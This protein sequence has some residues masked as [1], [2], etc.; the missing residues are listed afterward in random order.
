MVSTLPAFY[1]AGKG[2]RKTALFTEIELLQ[3]NVTTDCKAKF[4]I[5]LV[6]QAHCLTITTA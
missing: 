4:V 6:G 2:P 1:L 3:E 5:S